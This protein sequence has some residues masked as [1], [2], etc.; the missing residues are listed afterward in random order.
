METGIYALGNVWVGSLRA[1]R[2]EAV[3]QYIFDSWHLISCTVL[4]LFS[5]NFEYD[6]VSLISV[7]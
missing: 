4:A 3:Q 1:T 2:K 7:L 5:F 6:D